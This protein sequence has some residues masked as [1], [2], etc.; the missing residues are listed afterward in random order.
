[1]AVSKSTIILTSGTTAASLI[2]WSSL[3]SGANNV[4]FDVKG[5]NTGK[6]IFLVA[7]TNSTDIGTTAGYIHFG[8]SATAAAGTSGANPYSANA[9][10]KM[11]VKTAPPTTDLTEGLT[12]SSAAAHLAISMFGPFESA[13]LKDSDGY[14]NVCKAKGTSDLGRVKIAAILLP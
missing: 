14:I 13:R 6:I 2:K 12:I 5:K 4:Y 10:G 7:N 1:M 3:A 11:I 9:L 8:A